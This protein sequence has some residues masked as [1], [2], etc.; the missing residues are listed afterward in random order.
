MAESKKP[1]GFNKTK[2]DATAKANR[3]KGNAKEDAK[4]R[5]RKKTRKAQSRQATHKAATPPQ[6]KV[7]PP[8]TKSR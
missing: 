2:A 6:G 4:K 5:A 7:E 1:S 3:E 8:K